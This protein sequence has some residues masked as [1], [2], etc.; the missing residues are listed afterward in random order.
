MTTMRPIE[1]EIIR[2]EINAIADRKRKAGRF[3]EVPPT[4]PDAGLLR[5]KK[6]NEWLKLEYGKPAAKPLFGSFWFEGELCIL[7]AD[8]NLGKSVLAVQIGDS[9]TKAYGIGPLTNRAEAGTPVLYLDFELGA[10]QFE[11]R[12]VD[13]RWGSYTFA[14]TFYR[15]EFNPAANDPVLYSSYETYVR[16]SLERAITNTRARVLIIDNI[17]YM[18]NG[19]ER[20][21]DAMPLMKTLKALKTKHNL[22]LLVLA[23]TPKRDARKP[24][25]VNDLQGSKMLI[26]FADSAFA[27]GQSHT[28]PELRYLKQVKQ[29]NQKE[30]FGENNVCLIRMEKQLNFLQYTFE[31][32]ARE[33]DHLQRPTQASRQLKQ[34]VMQLHQNGRSLRQI[35]TELCI[36]FTTAG[37]MLR[38]T[39]EKSP[40]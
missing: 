11:A 33:R 14:D 21:K 9:L 13:H 19:T 2:S 26:N 31:G 17:T 22:S 27:I 36:H 20:A 32:F 6:A 28:L 15:S 1:I 30:E 34:Q 3:N 29:R 16:E 40:S 35:A 12:Y 10:K 8:T 25:T 5:T 37:R 7:F 4:G 38:Q 39:K 24:L 18:G 23:H